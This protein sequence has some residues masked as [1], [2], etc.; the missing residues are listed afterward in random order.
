MVQVVVKLVSAK[1]TAPYNTGPRRYAWPALSAAISGTQS[2]VADAC[3]SE[4]GPNLSGPGHVPRDIEFRNQNNAVRENKTTNRHRR[5]GKLANGVTAAC[6]IN[7]NT[8]PI[9][10]IGST[11]SLCP[12]KLWRFS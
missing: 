6:R 10:L 1:T 12:K 9:F 4:A 3:P 8:G 2:P 5:S 7:G 11:Q